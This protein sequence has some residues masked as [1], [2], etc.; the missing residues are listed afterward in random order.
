MSEHD[1]VVELA[2]LGDEVEH[3]RDL[4][5]GVREEPGEHLHHAGR[6][7]LLVGRQRVP[8]AAPMPVAPSTAVP[9]G[10]NPDSTW[11]ANTSSRQR[12]QPWS[13]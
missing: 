4:R 5:V 12:S 6:E 7:S 1:R 3:P 8:R 13:K 2:E 10:S 9:G 11:R